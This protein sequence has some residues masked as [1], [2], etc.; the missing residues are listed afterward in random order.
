MAARSTRIVLRNRTDQDLT[1]TAS[2]LAHGE[3][4]TQPPLNVGGHADAEWASE[5]AGFLTG[6]EGS[7]TFAV[8]GDGSSL[9]ID[10]DNPFAG[11]NK[12]AVDV[13]P[14]YALYQNGWS[15]EDAVV[16][17]VLE[18]STFRAT[19]F[20]PS[21]HGFPYPNRWD[22]APLTTIDLG[23]ASIPVGNAALGLCGGMVY[24]ALDHFGAGLPVPAERPVPAAPGTP[25][26]D[27]LVS[28]LVDSFDL[29]DLPVRLLAVMN[30]AYPDTGSAGNPLEGRSAIV[31]KDAWPQIRQWVDAGWPAPV[32]L[33]QTISANPFDL[34]LN[35]QTC[36]WGYQMDGTRVTLF[37]YD[38]NL[39]GDDTASIAFDASDVLKPPN[40]AVSSA[41]QSPVFCFFP[42]AYTH[43]QPP[44]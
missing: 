5:S 15:G 14:G 24:T 2:S 16:E 25:L 18:P 33:V 12:Y 38:P 23:V 29:P 44:V 37:T 36:V 11:T 19:N 8:G 31:L 30:P 17:Y 28:R 43:R 26:Y 3:W 6:T 42:T 32:C 1:L 10:W 9:R 7:A 27:H 22:E 21:T 34:G 4:S 20:R 39:P 35:H 40:I 13:S 41:G